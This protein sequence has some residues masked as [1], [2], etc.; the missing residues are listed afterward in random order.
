MME[1]SFSDNSMLK[2]KRHVILFLISRRVLKIGKLD[3]VIHRF[4]ASNRSLTI[5]TGVCNHNISLSKYKL[6]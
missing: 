1:I 4:G 3:L 6:I 5:Y 2:S